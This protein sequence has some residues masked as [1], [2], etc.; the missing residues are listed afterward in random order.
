MEAVQDSFEGVEE[1]IYEGYA[2]SRSSYWVT[3]SQCAWCNGI[4][5]GR[6]YVRLPR[7]NKVTYHQSFHLPLG[8]SLT[9][10]TSHGLC[11]SCAEKVFGSAAKK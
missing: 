11:L 9:I 8:S 6:W 5:L 10:T 2:E 1:M 3:I 7:V 4:K